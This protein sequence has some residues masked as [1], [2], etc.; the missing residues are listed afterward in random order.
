M[1]DPKDDGLCIPCAKR[2]ILAK[3]Q[4]RGR[5][6]TTPQPIPGAFWRTADKDMTRMQVVALEKRDGKEY[7]RYVYMEGRREGQTRESLKRNFMSNFVIEDD[8]NRHIHNWDKKKRT[9]HWVEERKAWIRKYGFN[10]GWDLG[11]D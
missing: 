3:K 6:A 11:E 5:K 7:V 2:N 8:S 10:P 9:N 1:F 4:K